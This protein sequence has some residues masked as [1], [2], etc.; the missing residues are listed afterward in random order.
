MVIGLAL[1]R[2]R[3]R[4]GFVGLAAVC[5]LLLS[6]PAYAQSLTSSQWF[7]AA[8]LVIAIGAALFALIAMSVVR[9]LV[10]R[11][12]I[13]R[14]AANGHISM[15]RSAVDDYEALLSGLPE[16]T[17][18]WT[19]GSPAPRVL[20]QVNA[21]MPQDADP[22]QLFEFRSWLTPESSQML[23]LALQA[24]RNDGVTFEEILK[25]R[26]G[27]GLR[28][29]G[30]VLGAGVALRLRT[31]PAAPATQTATAKSAAAAI[32][33]Q[34]PDPAALRDPA[35]ALIYANPAWHALA[36]AMGRPGS[37]TTP[38][39][40]GAPNLIR[41]NLGRHGVF[42]RIAGELDD[43]G[44]DMLRP[45]PVLP[46]E[47]PQLALAH[48]GAV[49]DALAAP[50]AVFGPKRELLHANPA[51]LALWSLDAEWLQPGM[52]EREILDRLRT[53]GLL[54]DEADYKAWRNKHLTSYGLKAPR[55][56]QWH[57]PDRRTINVM[58]APAGT[59]GG[60][61]YVFE[62]LTQRLKLESQNKALLGVQRETLNALN[63][64]V[65]VFGTN[66][67]LT[68]FNPRLATLWGFSSNLLNKFPHI[69]QLAQHAAKE[70]PADGS[71]IWA[72]LKRG[73]VDLNPNRADTRGRI[74]RA[75]G[76]LL[77]YALTRLPDGQTMMTFV[78]VTESA[79]YSKLLKERNDALITADRLKD[80]FV[81]NVSY[82][83]RSPLTNIIGFAD[84]LASESVGP[85]NDK[86]KAYTGYIRASSATLGVLVDNI[87]DLATV[88]A[89]IAELR[90]E[91]QDVEH[92]VDLARAGLAASFPPVDGEQPINLVLDIAPNLPPFVADG[93]RIVQVLYNLLSNAARF[94]E[95][96]AEIRLSIFGRG[97]DRLLFVVEDQGTGMS[98][99]TAAAFSGR[100]PNLA[101]RQRAAG[102]GLAI[103]K[104]FVN[105]HG[106]TIGVEARRP[107]GTR[108]IV[109]LPA[110]AAHSTGNVAE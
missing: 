36:G 86:Q 14:V 20:G 48:M 15:L 50:V 85:L 79:N 10:K 94:S 81:Q 18:M 9:S 47:P 58:A 67:R 61:I 29:S 60:V 43:L 91:A 17:V 41:L 102:L 2:F 6:T 88:D 59:A 107:R 37:D 103:V 83:L 72:N 71:P 3:K 38:A 70:F 22:D 34:L 28:A 100:E 27:R 33:A 51:Y 101:G 96:G 98:E 42:E 19:P 32:L 73:I 65:A 66:G 77:D 93:T 30:W 95:P 54:P 75:D 62:D 25:T 45:V 16:I 13:V 97:T 40:L 39:E 80:A 63:E 87:L 24:L 1:E 8:P 57:L 46:D 35:G 7:G 4:S 53:Q 56:E 11:D 82:E 5:V 90:P 49:I 84:L 74:T 69:D 109:N 21:V 23:G 76:R 89:G 55:Q 44:L 68:L 105:L 104:T 99:D 26:E 92:L 106:G 52:D 110:I 31:A 64:G 108:V 12:E 78:D